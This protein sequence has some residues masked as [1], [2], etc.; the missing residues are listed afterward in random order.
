MAVQPLCGRAYVVKGEG[1][2]HA[3]IVASPTKPLAL[4]VPA[5]VAGEMRMRYGRTEGVVSES[6]NHKLTPNTTLR[7]KLSF[8]ATSAFLAPP[9]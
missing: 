9:G 1:G 2:V 6:S 7:Q 5:D 3:Q 8:S 4:V